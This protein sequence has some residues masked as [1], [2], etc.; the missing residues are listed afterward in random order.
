MR[1]ENMGHIG[2][3]V[4]IYACDVIV[5]ISDGSTALSVLRLKGNELVEMRYS[6]ND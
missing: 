1:E 6:V 3:N 5:R 4:I 2:T